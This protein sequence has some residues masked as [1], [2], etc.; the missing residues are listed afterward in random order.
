MKADGGRQRIPGCDNASDLWRMS[1]ESARRLRVLSNQTTICVLK[2]HH[3]I[4]AS[5]RL[6]T[7]RQNLTVAHVPCGICCLREVPAWH[8][9][10]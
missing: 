10:A 3:R 9:A 2:R 5:L 6:S 8:P 1:D 7:S 4:L